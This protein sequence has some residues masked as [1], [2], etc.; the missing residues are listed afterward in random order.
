MDGLYICE[1]CGKTDKRL[2]NHLRHMKTHD[3]SGEKFE[4]IL[5]G[6]LLVSKQRLRT[7]N[8]ICT[9]DKYKCYL[10]PRVYRAKSQ[11]KAHVVESHDPK[12]MNE[13]EICLDYWSFKKS[14]VKAHKKNKHNYQLIRLSIEP[15]I[16]SQDSN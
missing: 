14:D 7:H 3:D 4:C 10:C 6:K 12:Y 15:T 1:L 2:Y 16:V 13:C 9:V 8:I 5:C 11:L